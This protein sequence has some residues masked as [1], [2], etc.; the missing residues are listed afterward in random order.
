MNKREL[1]LKP[2]WNYHDI[3]EYL[4]CKKS[5][6]YELMKIAREEHNGDVRFNPQVITRDSFLLTIQ[7]SIE[8]EIY[9]LN[10][11]ENS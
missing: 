9:I 10:C 5:K 6:A 3:C 4:S 8:R 11:I 7:T 2:V 1:L